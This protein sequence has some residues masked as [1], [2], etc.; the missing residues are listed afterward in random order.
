MSCKM[1]L[2]EIW[3]LILYFND[4]LM[5]FVMALKLTTKYRGQKSITFERVYHGKYLEIL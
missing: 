1:L 4:I 3:S 5:T 2:L